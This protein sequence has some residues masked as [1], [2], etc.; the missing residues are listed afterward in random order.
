MFESAEL[1]HRLAKAEYDRQLEPLR[2]TCW[3][4]NTTW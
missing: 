3:M 4:P 1:G 2:P